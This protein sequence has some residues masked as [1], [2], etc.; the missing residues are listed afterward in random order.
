MADDPLHEGR[1]SRTANRVALRL[2]SWFALVGVAWVALTD[3]VLVG[4]FEH[5]WSETWPRSVNR[6]AFVLASTAVVFL[7]VRLHARRQTRSAVALRGSEERFRTLVERVPG[8]VYLNEVDPADPKTTRC[9]Y[10]GPQLR[11]LLGYDPDEWIADVDLWLEV[12]HPEDRERVAAIN[13]GADDTGEL[14]FE[15]RAIARDGRTVWIHDEAVPIAAADGRPG[16]WLGVMVDITPQRA[17]DAALRELTESLRGVFVASP[18]AI[19]VLA[20]GGTVRHWNPAAERM[21]G[22]TADEVIGRPLPYV[23]QDKQEEFARLRARVI[24]GEAFSGVEVTR[25]RKDG[26]PIEVS[27]STAPSYDGD[28]NVEGIVAVIEDITDRKRAEAE[29]RRA[30][31]SQ[32]RLATRLEALH[33]IDRNVLLAGS[34]EEMVGRS[35]DHLR[36]LVGCDRAAVGSLDPLSGRFSYGGESSNDLDSPFGD[37]EISDRNTRSML[38]REVLSIPDVETVRMPTPFTGKALAAGI[39]SVLSVALLA[40]GE[41]LGNLIL[42]SRRPNAFDEEA[43]DIAK[44]VASQLAI[45]MRQARLREELGDRVGQLERLAEE[46]RQLLHRIVRA[47]E[48][49]RER[50]ALELHDGLGQ[51]LTSVSLF[52]SDLERDIADEAKPRAARVNALIRQAIGDSRRLVWSLR[53]PELERL[54]LVPALRRLAED[55]SVGG[56][57]VVDLHEEI[58]DLRLIP[59]T[60][61]VVYRVVQEALNNAQKHARASAISIVLRRAGARLSTLIED[62]GRGFDPAAI[63]RGQGIGLIGMRERAELVDGVLVIESRDG[64]GTRIRLDVPVTVPSERVDAS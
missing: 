63:A 52:A 33:E 6:G 34:V 24:D 17:A 1:A 9:V 62:N 8:I 40:E 12:V 39:R 25:V 32:L 30:I 59:E 47:Q 48:E 45:A 37:A 55:A 13:D 27:L 23:P 19:M 58:G 44:E 49:E 51:V 21:F 18:L 5:R 38:A 54:G 31:E 53:P 61:A 41:Q 29:R 57:A 15:Y 64:S 4:A 26:S 3:V 56:E 46:R 42:S 28:G 16:Y 20:P 2:A 35:L 43:E 7:L 60:E 50:V 22:W 36:R 11:E 10:V 14:K